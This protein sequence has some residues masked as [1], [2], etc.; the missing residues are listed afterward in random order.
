MVSQQPILLVVGADRREFSAFD[1]VEQVTS[2]SRVR[3][4]ARTLLPS[5]PALLV[6][7]GPGRENAGHA[8]QE[9]CSSR[10]V[11]AIISTGFVGALD[12]TL[13]LADV[14]I[15]TCVVQQEPKLQY[16]V[17]LP[18][19]SGVRE[20]TQGSLLT[21][22]KVVQTA[23]DRKKLRSLGVSAVDME[24]SA[25]AA[26]AAVRELPFFCVRVV[27]DEA[28]VSLPVVFNKTRRPNGTFSEWRVLAQALIRPSCWSRLRQL[29]IDSEQAS[30]A[31]AGFFGK[32]K[33]DV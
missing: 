31:L 19:W 9:I 12:E 20:P 3:W 1:R 30:I 15:A 27:S 23:H 21:V 13:S 4:E 18:T 24:A 5:G 25:V 8:V 7:H 2:Q 17:K 29:K 33:F 28:N 26:E 22:D 16:A 6:A 10:P 11:A 32:A 14:F